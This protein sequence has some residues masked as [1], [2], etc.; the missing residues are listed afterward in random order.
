[1]PHYLTRREAAQYLKERYK[2]GSYPWL[3][4]LAA[5]GTGPRHHRFGRAVLYSES[6]LEDWAQHNIRLPEDQPALTP[7]PA[8]TTVQPRIDHDLVVRE[9]LRVINASP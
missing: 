7:Q 9:A 8:T 2:C 4:R 3:T 1:M 5:E 6:D